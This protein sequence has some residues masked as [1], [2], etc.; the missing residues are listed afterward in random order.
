MNRQIKKINPDLPP[1][2]SDR[3]RMADEQYTQQAEE[4]GA[5]EARAAKEPKPADG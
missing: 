4:R 5:E 1:G 3:L 2:R